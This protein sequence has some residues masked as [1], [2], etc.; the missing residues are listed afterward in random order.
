MSHQNRCPACGNWSG[1]REG[2][3]VTFATGADLDMI[4]VSIQTI[5]FLDERGDSS[6]WLTAR[7]LETALRL[8]ILEIG[9]RNEVMAI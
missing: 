8:K 4:L 9:G 6:S 2:C 5:T 7:T 3:V 1:H